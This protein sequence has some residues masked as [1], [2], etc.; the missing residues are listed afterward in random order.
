[1]LELYRKIMGV[2]GPLLSRILN[3]RVS[4]GKEDRV[5]MRERMGQASRFRPKGQVA[6]FHAAS[7]GE[8]QST[9]V[10]IDAFLKRY[11]DLHI[12]VTTGTVTSAALL[13]GRLPNSVIHQF[14]PL[15]HPE[16]VQAFLDHW[17]PDAVFWMESELW[18]LMLGEIKNRNISAVLINARLSDRSFK[19]WKLAGN[20]PGK[21]LSAFSIILAQTDQDQTRFEALG[22]RNVHVTSN[23]K[24][25]A[26]PLPFDPAMLS[27]LK[28][29]IRTRP[30]W[31]YASTHAG[32]EDL[33]CRLHKKLLA[34]FPDLLTVIVPRHPERRDA[35]QDTVTAAG[36]KATLRSRA[37]LPEP[38]DQVYIA[39]TLGELGLFYTLCPVACVGRSFSDDGGGG[40]NPIEPARLG[41]AVLV[42]P[43]VQN[44]T[45]VYLD[46]QA[47]GAVMQVNTEDEFL[48]ALRHLLSDTA[49]RDA[50]SQNGLRFTEDQHQIVET[51]LAQ[52]EPM[53]AAFGKRD[54]PACA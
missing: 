40:H 20:M 18:P 3:R 36:L 32:E 26:A 9:L 47:A 7:V 33:A 29:R 35:V 48:N 45:Q 50:L 2:S 6:W 52:L 31:L 41:C 22:A 27:A 38:D 39:D 23:L 46:M 11:P 17:Q 19:R 21:V 10:L 28:T 16:W 8:A 53:L 44:Q 42:G 13:R 5:R 24:Y 14:Y 4:G 49:A 30:V 12:L 43:H 51:V 37:S 34:D 15:D 54:L 1:M 25:G